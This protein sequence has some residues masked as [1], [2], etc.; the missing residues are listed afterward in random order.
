MSDPN[1]YTVYFGGEL[2]SAKHLFGN[3]ALAEA[4]VVHRDTTGPFRDRRALMKVPRLGARAFELC[5]GFLR[6]GDGDE[7]ADGDGDEDGL[8]V[9]GDPLGCGCPE[10]AAVGCGDGRLRTRGSD[11]CHGPGTV[12]T[13]ALCT[14][15]RSPGWIGR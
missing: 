6:I 7:P 10:G 14:V 15:P 13:T 11:C 12:S 8:A 1:T 5:A 2:F 3:A 9:A 4:I